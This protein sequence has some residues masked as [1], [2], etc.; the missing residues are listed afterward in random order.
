MVWVPFLGWY[1]E[2]SPRERGGGWLKSP[3]LDR[4]AMISS[5][6]KMV[7]LNYYI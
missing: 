5:S 1:C 3:N 4:D 7:V 6:A 2:S